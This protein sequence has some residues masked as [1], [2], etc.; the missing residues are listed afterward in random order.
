MANK[1]TEGLRKLFLSW[2]GTEPDQ[3]L[4]LPLSG[5]YRQ[6]FRMLS[7]TGASVLGVTNADIRENEAYFSFTETFRKLGLKVPE[8]F[9]ISRDR[10]SYLVQDLGDET[11][12]SFLSEKNKD[13]G[14]L[15]EVELIYKKVIEELP[16]F[17]VI[18]TASLDF[19]RCYPRSSFD[20]QSMM[21]DLNYFK[22]Y[23][24]KLARVPFDEQK[25]ENDFTHLCDYLLKAPS[26][27]F[28]YRDFQSRNIMLKDGSP[29]FIDFQG[30]RKGAL[31]YDLASLLYDAKAAIPQQYRQSL[32]DHYILCLGKY[33]DTGEKAFREF[34][35]GFVLIRILQAM[36]AY[37]FRGYYEKKEHFLNSIPYAIENIR[38]LLDNSKINIK[39]PEL[40]NVLREMTQQDYNQKSTADIDKLTVTIYSFS[41]K[42]GI[43][44]DHTGNG[45]GFVFDCRALPN[46][47]RYE[48]YKDL[49]GRDKEVM[50]FLELHKEVRAFLDHV[51][52]ITDQSV[53]NYRERKFSHL[54]ICFGCT[55]G[56]HRSVYCAG[57][58]GKY[59]TSKHKTIS[60]KVINRE[61]A[62]V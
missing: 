44:S 22:Y 17:Q 35:Y 2:T 21:W 32:L 4:P 40:L 47:G 34:Y 42:N 14:F 37:G 62:S 19:F 3:V 60:V 27:F 28:L 24:L 58:L 59:L 7:G 52:S 29:W 20:R 48:Q 54:M 33:H 16:V 18:A 23:F 49:T 5:S 11:L 41:Y 55:G 39:L 12:F 13:G 25:L 15:P 57:E 46:P 43:P 26:S 36:G 31:Q 9:V 50:R 38:W 45:G 8:I 51:F 30:G 6:Y 61:I 1:N 10:K 56:K 53:N